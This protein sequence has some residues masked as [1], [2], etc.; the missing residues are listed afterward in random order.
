[1]RT[2]R[3]RRRCR[4]ACEPGIQLGEV[5]GIGDVRS[6]AAGGECLVPLS[7]LLQLTRWRCFGEVP[8]DDLHQRV[9]DRLTQRRG[10][11]KFL[12]H[13][14]AIAHTL[15]QRLE[16]GPL[17]QIDLCLSASMFP[18]KEEPRLALPP[19]SG[20]V[21]EASVSVAIS[22]S[23]L[24][25]PPSSFTFSAAWRNSRSMMLEPSI[26]L[27]VAEG[28]ADED[29]E[30]VRSVGHRYPQRVARETARRHAIHDDGWMAA[31]MV[32]NG[33][34]PEVVRTVS[35]GRWQSGIVPWAPGPTFLSLAVVML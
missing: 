35:Q 9:V 7:L 4:C 24:I 11:A 8:L 15:L 12:D 23:S 22:P 26:F 6:P 16:L 1:M 14:A 31:G 19:A 28:G 34:S 2:G 33:A 27:Q 13:E 30:I 18:A 5:F 21:R 17:G 10:L 20:K 32:K 29:A 25:L 3:G